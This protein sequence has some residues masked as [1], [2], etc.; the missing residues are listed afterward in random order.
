MFFRCYKLNPE[1]LWRNGNAEIPP[2]LGSVP[3]FDMRMRGGSNGWKGQKS[4]VGQEPVEGDCMGTVGR[5]LERQHLR[6]VVTFSL[7]DVLTDFV[8]LDIA[9]FL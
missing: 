1:I 7:Y 5:I 6:P 8:V 2:S 9:S 4:T 3:D